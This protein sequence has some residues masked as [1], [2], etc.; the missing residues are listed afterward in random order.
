VKPLFVRLDPDPDPKRRDTLAA[1]VPAGDELV[2]EAARL[3]GIDE[4]VPWLE[5]AGP[6]CAG[7]FLDSRCRAGV[8][9]APP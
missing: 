2:A 5:A 3:A 7:I 9:E 1:L 4:V 6:W 8:K